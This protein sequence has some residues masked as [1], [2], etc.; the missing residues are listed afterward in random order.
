[1]EKLVSGLTCS[2]H[3]VYIDNMSFHYH[4]SILYSTLNINENV[5]LFIAVT[6]LVSIFLVFNINIIT[7]VC[8]NDMKSHT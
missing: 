2:P 5:Y 1:M 4:L 3:F 8:Y 7:N 6:T